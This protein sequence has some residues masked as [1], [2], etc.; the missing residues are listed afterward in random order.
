MAWKMAE[1]SVTGYRQPLER[2]HRAWLIHRAIT[3]LLIATSAP[4]FAS[5]TGAVS[6]NWTF[7]GHTKLHTLFSHVPADS[8]LHETAGDSLQRLELETRLKFKLRQG[9]MDF[10]THFQVLAQH[11]DK[12][13]G[14][15]SGLITMLS[16]SGAMSDTRRWFSLTR[17]V[18]PNGKNTAFVRLDRFSVG[19]SGER[20]AVRFGRQA[21][22]WGNG[23]LFT[24]MDI[25]NPFDP[26]AV[27]REYKTGDDMLYTQWTLAGGNDIQAVAVVRRDP[28]DGGVASSQSSLATKF[29]C[30]WGGNE[31]DLLLAQ[32]YDDLVLAL[33][34][35][36]SA[37]EAVWRADLVWTDTQQGSIF[38]AVAGTT[39]SWVSGQ[40]NW[41]ALLEYF[42]NGFGQAHGQYS[43]SDLAARPVL[44]QRLARGELFNLGR[45]YFGASINIEM[46][47]LL[48][49][50]PNVFVN[51]GDPS[52]LV[53][54]VLRYDW[55]QNVQILTVLDFPIGAGGTEYGGIGTQDPAKTI[56]A[57]PAVFAQLA[58][59]F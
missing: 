17:S 58:W 55:L 5:E 7:G 15:Q 45:H 37:A 48:N 30:F 28:V 44:V 43:G 2:V 26:A 59:Y 13:P 25:F 38:S 40:R 52:A 32:H 8:V 47:P 57:G 49:A 54:L 12:L 1:L 36:V 27:D 23:L 29:H 10:D 24:P 33:G 11:A 6:S 50:G 21:L 39:Y 46:T 20:L 9:P 35:S 41:S 51:L 4:V 22:S 16:G 56:S 42:Y 14:G 53:Q 34:A 31:Y 3:I 18:S 19:Y